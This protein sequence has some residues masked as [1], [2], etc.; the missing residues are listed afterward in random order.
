MSQTILD[1]WNGNLAPGEHCGSHD[2]EANRILRLMERD[3]EALCAG[4]T[5]GQKELLQKYIDCSED[6]LFRMMELAF[7]DGFSLAGKLVTEILT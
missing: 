1:L 5:A 7:C 2:M 6:Y 4:L 3:R